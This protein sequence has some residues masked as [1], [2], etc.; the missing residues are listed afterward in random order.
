MISYHETSPH[1]FG[2]VFLFSEN[3]LIFPKRYV[4]IIKDMSEQFISDRGGTPC[5]NNGS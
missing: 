4:I 2:E 5:E 1:T 3:V